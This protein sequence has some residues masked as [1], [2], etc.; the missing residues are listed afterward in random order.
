MSLET[1]IEA[2]LFYQAEPVPKS[3][4]SELFGV[5][6]GD[7]DVALNTLAE[8]LRNRGV[9]L[10]VTETDAQLVTAPEVSELIESVRK[11]ELSADIGR[12]GAETL[13]IVLYRGPLTRAEIDSIRGVNS[14]FILRNL[15]I[16]G[17]IER[18]A[19]PKDARSYVYSITT[20]LL[21]H[22]GV[23]RRE[24]LPEFGEVMNSLDAFEREEA[25]RRTE[26]D[27]LVP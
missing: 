17:L 22:L 15:L 20:A 10:I 8:S 13:A 7:V 11:E 5:A 3:F 4:L 18:R 14:T 1:Q 6:L 24:A 25:E 12:A 9:R 26:A 21:S 19:H 23:E 27:S 2:I 16:R